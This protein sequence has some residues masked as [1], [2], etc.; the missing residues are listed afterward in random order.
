MKSSTL[1]D[2]RLRVETVAS[3]EG[4]AGLGIGSYA[5][6]CPLIYIGFCAAFCVDAPF[7]A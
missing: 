3:N 1:G 7:C 2:R 5:L 6:L 4:W